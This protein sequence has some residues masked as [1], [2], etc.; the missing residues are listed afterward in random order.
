MYI[1]V[2]VGEFWFFLSI[3]VNHISY[4]YV[5]GSTLLGHVYRVLCMQE[6]KKEFLFE[7]VLHVK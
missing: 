4:R 2:K 5:G 7:N 6:K 3:D 1:V